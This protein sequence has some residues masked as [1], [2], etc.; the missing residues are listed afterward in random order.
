MTMAITTQ[1]RM[2]RIATLTCDRESKRSSPGLAFH[3]VDEQHHEEQNV[4]ALEMARAEPFK[5]GNPLR[6]RDMGDR[7]PLLDQDG[8]TQQD[9]WRD[10]WPLPKKHRQQQDTEDENVSKAAASR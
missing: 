6:Y 4:G 2:A 5:Q 3:Q 10:V 7:R 8:G 1:A 9:R